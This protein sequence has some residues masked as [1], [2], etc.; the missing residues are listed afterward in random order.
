[1]ETYDN[2]AFEIAQ[3]YLKELCR[4][5][6][7]NLDPEDRFQEVAAF[8]ICALHSLPNNS[9]HFLADFEAQLFPHMQKLN[10]KAVF[11]Y[12]RPVSLTAPIPCSKKNESATLLDIL[13]APGLDCSRIEVQSFL[14]T[15]PLRQQ[16]ILFDLLRGQSNAFV[17][18]KY[19]LSAYRLN[20]IKQ[21]IGSCYLKEAAR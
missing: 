11:L 20:R 5:R 4:N 15:L 17:A 13:S 7:K 16:D 6:W 14:K 19:G 1:M 10:Q 12:R 21:Q 18:Q 8:Y 3:A 2:Q 9:G